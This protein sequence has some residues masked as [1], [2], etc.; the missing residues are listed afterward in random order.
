[1]N[2]VNYNRRTFGGD[3]MKKV[4]C[5]L[6]P[7]VS[8][9]MV[10]LMHS[11]EFEYIS[12]TEALV[13]GVLIGIWFYCIEG[14]DGTRGMLTISVITLLLCI[15]VVGVGFFIDLVE[16]YMYEAALWSGSELIGIFIL[17]LHK[18]RQGM[19]YSYSYRNNKRRYF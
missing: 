4:F 16:P 3:V 2:D 11:I 7:Y 13:L 18:P 19:S 6:L 17:M 10:L 1:M 8:T 5:I 15:G 14:T 9:V 12:V